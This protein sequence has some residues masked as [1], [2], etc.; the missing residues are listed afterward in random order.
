VTWDWEI[1]PELSSTAVVEMQIL[2]VEYF[3]NTLAIDPIASPSHR[4][5]VKS[6][7]N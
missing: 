5:M 7:A 2:H 6:T 4:R 3:A 1:H